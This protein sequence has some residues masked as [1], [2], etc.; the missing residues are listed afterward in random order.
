MPGRAVPD[1]FYFLF[2]LENTEVAAPGLDF[3]NKLRA[4]EAGVLCDFSVFQ[5]LAFGWGSVA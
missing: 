3:W 2:V 5:A 4:L 1:L